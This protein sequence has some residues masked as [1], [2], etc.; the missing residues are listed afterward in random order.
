VSG[1]L[2]G[3]VMPACGGAIRIAA[4]SVSAAPATVYSIGS[5]LTVELSES[6]Q[7]RRPILF[8]AG[9]TFVTKRVGTTDN[10]QFSELQQQ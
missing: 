7:H 3:F 1:A 4:T 10:T 5:A 9:F 2:H 8:N 6:L